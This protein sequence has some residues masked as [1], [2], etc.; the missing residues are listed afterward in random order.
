M[1]L[2]PRL[3]EICSKL[4]LLYVEDDKDTR[5]Q[6]ERIFQ[7]LFR[8]VL[9][10]ENGVEALEVYAQSPCDL[11]IT[12][13][14]MPKMDGIILIGEL[15]KRNEKQH[16]IVMTA[17]NTSENLR[18]SIE[19]MVDGILIKPVAMQKLGDLL[20]KTCQSIYLEQNQEIPA[21]TQSRKEAL[22]RMLENGEYAVCLALIDGFDALV[23]EFGV[24]VKSPIIEAARSHLSN[25]GKTPGGLP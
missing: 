24:E 21:D 3:K 10:A 9:T 18:D 2:N 8:E 17:H 11:V 4:T 13:L 5:D 19:L 23:K 22:V 1:G 25:F 6:Y 20:F 14:T 12:D 16:I 15:R 7:L